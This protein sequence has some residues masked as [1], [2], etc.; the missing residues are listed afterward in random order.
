M[1]FANAAPLS[2]G[3]TTATLPLYERSPAQAIRLPIQVIEQLLAKEE[4][5]CNPD[6]ICFYPDLESMVALQRQNK[7][8]SQGEIFVH[9]ASMQRFIIMKQIAP[10]SCEFLTITHEGYKDVLTAYRFEQDE[11]VSMLQAFLA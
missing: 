1:Y 7:N 4:E 8:W 2:A 6:R 5:G 9:A 10:S 3:V 11:L